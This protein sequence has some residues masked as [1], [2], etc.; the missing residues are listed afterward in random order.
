[1]NDS[2]K[3]QLMKNRELLKGYQAGDAGAEDTDQQQ[4]LPGLPPLKANKGEDTIPLPEDFSKLHIQGNFLELISGRKSRRQFQEDPL[5]LTELSY[6]LWT[7]QGVRNVAGHKN[8]VTFRNVPSAGSRHPFETYL[9]VSKV[10]GLEKG[11]YHYLP[12]K[13]RLELWED[14][15]DYEGELTQALCGQRFAAFAPAVFV[16]SALPY[17]TE[18]RYGGKAAKYILLDAG[19][20][21]ENL[22]LACQS[23]GC[24]TCAIGAYDQERLD[25]LLGFAP[26]PSG[27]KDYE[28]A[29]Y[30]APVGKR[31]DNV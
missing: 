5:T 30:A 7:T 8:P 29:V 18:W 14:K 12:E 28:C 15:K 27:E 11:I 16:W 26:G 22:Y 1:M 23:I 9:F 21:C 31:E 25:D 3:Y 4:K 2:T 6:L 17:R 10:E 20:M 13:H 24:G 19:H